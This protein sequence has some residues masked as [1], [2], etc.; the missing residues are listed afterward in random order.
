IDPT[1]G[2]IAEGRQWSRGL[3]QFIELKEDLPLSD[4]FQPMAR[5][6]YQ[7][8]FPRYLQL[9]GTSA[10]LREA[11]SELLSLYGLAVVSVPLHRPSQRL[12]SA[13]VI[14]PDADLKWAMVVR[15]VHHECARNRP[16]L[17][18]TESV[19]DSET[20]SCHLDAANI[21]HVV[22]NARQDAEEAKIVA[23]AG[24]AGAVTVATNMAGRGTDIRIDANVAAHGGLHVISCQ[25]N[26]TRRIERQLHGR[27]ARQGKPGSV[28]TILS[29]HE[30]LFRQQLP[31]QLYRWLLRTFTS[32]RAPLPTW[33]SKI[34]PA[35]ARQRHERMQRSIRSHLRRS[36][37]QNRRLLGVG[38]RE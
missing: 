23:Q 35:I 8:F 38:G 1:T 37:A 9:G 18:A 30:P 15:Q 4:A 17:I 14:Y 28:E 3:H 22:L 11:R 10:T 36:D 32:R 13:T 26:G 7:R 34:L 27:C 24:K 21:P 6:T 33:V 31:P 25:L 2:R 20:L 29:L 12:T 5:I 16:V 19:A